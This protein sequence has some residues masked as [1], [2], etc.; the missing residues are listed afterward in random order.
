MEAAFR[1]ELF[2]KHDGSTY[3]SGWFREPQIRVSPT[4]S[5]GSGMVPGWLRAFRLKLVND[6]R[7]TP[8]VHPRLP[9]VP[10]WIRDGSTRFAWSSSVAPPTHV[11]L[12]PRLPM[13]PGW[14]RDGS[15]RFPMELVDDGEVTL[16][17]SPTASACS[18]MAL[19]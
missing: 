11:A 15:V 12:R 13:A 8:R 10:V 18:G 19:G 1:V 4:A 14:L 16:R 3:G 17:A 5:D 6:D 7:V 2:E 9:P